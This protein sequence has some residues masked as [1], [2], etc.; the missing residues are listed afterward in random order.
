MFEVERLDLFTEVG[1]KLSYFCSLNDCEKIIL[2]MRGNDA[3]IITWMAK[4]IH[5]SMTKRSG[6]LSS[7]HRE[8]DDTLD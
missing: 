1:D 6:I 2:L 7:K 5:H 3:Q 8:K 4:F